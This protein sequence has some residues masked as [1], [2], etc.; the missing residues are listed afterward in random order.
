MTKT[1]QTYRAEIVG[2]VDASRIVWFRLNTG[3]RDRHGTVFEP[4]GLRLEN[5]IRNPAF[6]W[7]H[8]DADKG[9]QPDDAIGRVLQIKVDDSAVLI[10]VEFARTKKASIC[11]QQVKDGF[12]RMVSIRAL[13]LRKHEEGD[14]VIVDEWELWS[15]SLCIVGS[16]PEALALRYL[17]SMSEEIPAMDLTTVLEKLG[18]AEGA[19]L[20]Q[21][22]IACCT[23]MA[24][25]DE[26]KA[27]L[28]AVMGAQPAGD[29]GMGAGED[30][31]AG[32]GDEPGDGA[33]E[34]RA[35]GGDGKDDMKDDKDAM[36]DA[37]DCDPAMRAALNMALSAARS[38]EPA[39]KKAGPQQDAEKW[40]D[41]QLA[42]GR[43]AATARAELLALAR[44]APKHAERAVALIPPGTFKVH[45]EKLADIAAAG[46][47]QAQTRSA[48]NLG[49]DGDRATEP[50]AE[51]KAKVKASLAAIG[52]ALV[53]R[54]PRLLT[55]GN[56]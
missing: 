24:R 2:P 18:L 14:V 38:A 47:A 25:S 54:S 17:L 29:G 5:F 3:A 30:R 42:A 48:P 32:E 34:D 52:S 39:A 53:E 19:S 7:N 22:L 56:S 41:K 31:A 46:A 28:A 9:C 12:L 55:K 43:W 20:Q 40:V 13:I 11:L 45:R 35:A 10:Q 44:S 49:P 23:M 27:M 1:P 6:V 36:R 21:M 15:A 51:V 8:R 4:S 26:D 16:N 33:T 50:D 37:K